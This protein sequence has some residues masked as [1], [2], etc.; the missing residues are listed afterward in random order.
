LLVGTH[1]VNV[2]YGAADSHFKIGAGRFQGGAVRR[3]FPRSDTLGNSTIL[4]LVTPARD[5]LRE[6]IF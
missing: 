6:G 2:P 5:H 4:R 3:D 1:V